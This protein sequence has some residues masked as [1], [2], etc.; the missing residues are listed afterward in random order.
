[1][2][3]LDRAVIHGLLDNECRSAPGVENQGKAQSIVHLEDL[4]ADFLAGTT[5]NAV[6]A[7][8]VW[9]GMGHVFRW[10]SML[11]RTKTE[12]GGQ[13]VKTCP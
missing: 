5:M 1:M 9:I 4:R 6:G 10:F 11:L 12:A 13:A 7:D 8:D 3:A 2:N